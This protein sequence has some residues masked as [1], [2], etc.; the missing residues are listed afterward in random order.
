MKL[1][2]LAYLCGIV[3]HG[4]NVSIAANALHTSQPGIS[5]QIRLLEDELGVDILI[6]RS[7]RIVG[8]TDQGQAIVTIARRV[9]WETKNI[10]LVG[11]EGR[12][13][14]LHPISIATTYVHARYVLLPLI[15]RFRARHPKVTFHIQQ[16]SHD[17][18]LELVGNGGVDMGVSTLPKKPPEEIVALPFLKLHRALITP[19]DHP[20]AK[21]QKV[22]LQ[23]LAKYPMI[24]SSTAQ[25]TGITVLN[26]F[27]A[28]KLV[29]DIVLSATDA[30]VIKAYVE[31]GVGIAVLSA[32]AYDAK[33]D[34]GICAINVDHLFEPLTSYITINRYSHLRSSIA[35]FIQLLSAK[36][37]RDAVEAAL[38]SNS[39][40]GKTRH[41][42]TAKKPRSASPR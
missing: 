11:G 39:P 24:T 31:A 4:L 14:R 21:K 38:K 34:I 36:W 26:A 32:E 2:Q 10:R 7:N 15:T 18:I 17:E 22:T 1:I 35:E 40:L 33:R 3:D 8:L 30:D 28:R 19:R 6:R 5:K 23:D 25:P 12:T 20:L 42:R 13:E 16:C 9:L 29:P 27:R 41:S 37:T